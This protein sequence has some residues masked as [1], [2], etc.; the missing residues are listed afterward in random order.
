MTVSSTVVPR[1]LRHVDAEVLAPQGDREPGHGDARAGTAS[2]RETRD[3]R[4]R[5][6][7][8]RRPGSAAQGDGD[9]AADAGADGFGARPEAMPTSVAAG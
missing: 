1:P 4:R 3:R 9:G 2:A 8:P 7:R 6:R 5:R